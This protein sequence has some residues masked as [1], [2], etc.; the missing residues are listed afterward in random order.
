[1]HRPKRKK[2]KLKRGPN[3]AKRSFTKEEVIEFLVSNDI[4]TRD[5]LIEKRKPGDPDTPGD[6]DPGDCR[7]LFG[8]WVKAKEAAFGRKE[9]VDVPCDAEY[10]ADL[11]I[12]FNVWRYDSYLEKHEESPEIFPSMCHIRSKWGTFSELVSYARA[13]SIRETLNKYLAL[14]RKLGKTPTTKQVR[15][16]GLDLSIA[17]RC[18]GGKRS[19]D[20]FVEDI[21]RVSENAKR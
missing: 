1:M 8:S 7:K 17:T 16:S 6:P 9:V 12:S 4:R 5:Q 20:R 15:D 10:L 14:R 21:M 11:L 2:K 13:R 18:F 3:E 19:L